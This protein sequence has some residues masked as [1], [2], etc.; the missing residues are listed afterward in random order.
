MSSSSA[1]AS[2]MKPLRPYRAG[3]MLVALWLLTSGRLSA[4]NY[5]LNLNGAVAG[6]GVTN[7][8]VYDAGGINWTTDSTGGS[9]TGTFAGRNTPVFSTGTDAAS[10]SYTITGNI[11]Q[12][13][14]A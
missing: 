5:Y 11:G 1:I 12:T 13:S 2:N 6:S 8:G 4:A 10:L 3:L 7:N 9:A 14:G